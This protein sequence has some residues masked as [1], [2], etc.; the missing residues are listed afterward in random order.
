MLGTEVKLISKLVDWASEIFKSGTWTLSFAPG[1]TCSGSV[2]LCA[3][4]FLLIPKSACVI[5]V[6][7]TLTAKIPSF[8]PS[9]PLPL[10]LIFSPSLLSQLVGRDAV[11]LPFLS[12]RTILKLLFGFTPSSILKLYAPPLRGFEAIAVPSLSKVA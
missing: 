2:T 9:F 11:I 7:A 1:L 12:L 8:E 4:G 5:S 10:E 6:W 3:S